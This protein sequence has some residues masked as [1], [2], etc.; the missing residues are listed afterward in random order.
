MLEELVELADAALNLSR[1]AAV[2]AMLAV[3]HLEERMGV[4]S[5]IRSAAAAGRMRTGTAATGNETEA[6]VD[7][8]I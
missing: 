7:E 3:I 8:G 6:D 1:A 2:A 5:G 4:R